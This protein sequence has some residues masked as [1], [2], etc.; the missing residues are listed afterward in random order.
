MTCAATAKVHSGCPANTPPGD[1]DSTSRV[2][3]PTQQVSLTVCT[4]GWRWDGW[5]GVRRTVG[6]WPHK[7]GWDSLKPN[8]KC[9]GRSQASGPSLTVCLASQ[10]WPDAPASPAAETDDLRSPCPTKPFW[11]KSCLLTSIHHQRCQPCLQC[12]TFLLIGNFHLNINSDS[13]VKD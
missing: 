4:L 1:T 2:W 6:I 11:S 12:Q 13:S 9:R 3:H 7:H 8:W 5:G 10:E